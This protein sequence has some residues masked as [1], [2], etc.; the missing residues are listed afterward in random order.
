[1]AGNESGEEEDLGPDK[2]KFEQY[3]EVKR[4]S[5]IILLTMNHA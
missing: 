1:M 4:K 2:K 3:R 5:F